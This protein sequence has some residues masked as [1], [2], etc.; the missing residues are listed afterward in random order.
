MINVSERERDVQK[1]EK[2]FFKNYIK[3]TILVL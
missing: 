2:Q 3:K 1:D